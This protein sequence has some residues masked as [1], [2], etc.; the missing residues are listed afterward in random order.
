MVH[1]KGK[2]AV[3]VDVP[4]WSY[5]DEE[6]ARDK[7]IDPVMKNAQPAIINIIFLLAGLVS[8]YFLLH[9]V[10]WPMVITEED[11]AEPPHWAVV[12]AAAGCFA[13]CIYAVYP[14]LL[15]NPSFTP[16]AHGPFS[17][18]GYVQ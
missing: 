6:A 17:R 11:A 4:P 14:V 3:A 15:P 18:N 5:A 13:A 1:K 9:G 7:L 10:L 16:P 8:F 2:E 12:A